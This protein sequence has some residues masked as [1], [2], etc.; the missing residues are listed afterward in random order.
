[1]LA[2]TSTWAQ[3]PPRDLRLYGE[4][5]VAH[6]G[7]DDAAPLSLDGHVNMMRGIIGH[8][9]H[10]NFAVESMLAL[11]DRSVRTSGTVQVGLLNPQFFPYTATRELSHIIG[12]Y[13]KPKM[14][15]GDWQLYARV[16][17][18]DTRVRSSMTVAGV[19]TA[20]AESLLDLSYGAGASWDFDPKS[21]VALDWMRYLDKRGLKIQGATLSIGRRW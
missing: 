12:F 2:S 11:G 13:A 16:G 14:R 3:E 19:T 18:A 10:P 8:E 5:G 7:I 1:M 4:L 6:L 17:L 9:A 21:F 15:M 20:S